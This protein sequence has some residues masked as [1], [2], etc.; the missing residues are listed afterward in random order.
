MRSHETNNKQQQ[1]KI[2]NKGENLICRL[3][4]FK[5]PI[6][7]MFKEVKGTMSKEQKRSTRMMNYQTETIKISFK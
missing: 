1:Q 2:L 3:V 6:L 4:K 5:T 7:S